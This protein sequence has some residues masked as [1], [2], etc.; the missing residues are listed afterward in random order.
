MTTAPDR[1]AVIAMQLARTDR[2]ALSQAWYDALHHAQPGSKAAA[3]AV[4][5]SVA[6]DA[7]RPPARRN[8]TARASTPARSGGQRTTREMSAH[9][10]ARDPVH[11]ARHGREATIDA[12]P[13][14]VG[15][16]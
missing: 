12:L 3:P 2:R 11:V 14:T 15:E 7:L 1:I 4:H 9:G 8:E 13:L 16:E 5:A 10:I 6:T